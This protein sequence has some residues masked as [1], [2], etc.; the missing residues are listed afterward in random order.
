M[1]TSGIDRIL[2][3]E[4]SGS[5]K[6]ALNRRR[7]SLIAGGGCQ[8]SLHSPSLAPEDR[9]ADLPNPINKVKF[10]RIDMR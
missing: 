9:L 2:F 5:R 4:D 10:L 1:T 3:L 8:D 7:E 6:R